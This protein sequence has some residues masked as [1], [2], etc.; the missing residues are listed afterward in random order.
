MYRRVYYEIVDKLKGEIER[1]Y[2][3]P[4]FVLYSDVELVLRKA[5]MGESIPPE[6]F[7]KVSEHF[8]DELYTERRIDYRVG[9][10]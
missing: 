10:A 6:R 4:T 7:S 9:Y 2:N 3:S 1:C 8:R 5:A